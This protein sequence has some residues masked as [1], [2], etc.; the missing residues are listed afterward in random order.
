MKTVFITGADRGNG[1]AF[2]QVFLNAGWHV[3]AGRYME[4]WKELD[5]LK[6]KANEFVDLINEGRGQRAEM[7]EKISVADQDAARKRGELD[8]SAELAR[9]ASALEKAALDTIADGVMTGDMAALSESHPQGV[10]SETFLR[11][12]ADRI[13]F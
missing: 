4:R 5:E 12:I 10:D 9:F 7:L 3:I 2:C 11:A 8:G 1:F 6:A 13:A